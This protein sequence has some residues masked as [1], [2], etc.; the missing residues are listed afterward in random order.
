MRSLSRRGF[1]TLLGGAGAAGGLLAYSPHSTANAEPAPFSTENE[2]ANLFSRPGNITREL[3]SRE[4]K[5]VYNLEMTRL[6]EFES[7]DGRT[8]IVSAPANFVSRMSR[9]KHKSVLLRCAQS[10]FRTAERV[11]IVARSAGRIGAPFSRASA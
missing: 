9:A 4:R 2:S 7:F 5:L 1:V 11:E 8:L 3:L 10:E 6:L